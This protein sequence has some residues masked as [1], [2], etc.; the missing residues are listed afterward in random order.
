MKSIDELMKE[1]ASDE[2]LRASLSEAAKSGTVDCFPK[3]QGVDAHELTDD[4][5]AAAT[6]GSADVLLSPPDP[7]PCKRS[8]PCGGVVSYLLR[9]PHYDN[10]YAYSCSMCNTVHFIILHEDGSMEIRVG[11]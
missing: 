3:S 1:I 2:K 4:E 9:I 11:G 5:T 8:R 7:F 10:A 6:G